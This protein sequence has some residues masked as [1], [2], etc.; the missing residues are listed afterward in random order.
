MPVRE[1]LRQGGTALLIC[2]SVACAS[3]E[4]DRS[5]GARADSSRETSRPVASTA[6]TPR[7]LRIPADSEVAD[8]N[9]RRSIARGRAIM[10]A[11]ADSLPGHVRAR[12]RCMS[13]HLD[14]GARVNGLPLIG[15]YVRYPQYRA[16]AGRV[17][18]IEDRVNECLER[19]LNG[20]AIAYDSQEM[21]DLVAYFAFMSRGTAVGDVVDGVGLTRLTPMEPD[22]VRGRALFD[23]RCASC[24]GAD[25]A[26]RAAVPPLW[27]PHAYNI[28]AGMARVRTAAA[29]IR[30]NMP[31][32]RPGSLTDQEAWDIAGYVNTRPRPD[33]APKIND[34]PL[35]DPPP[36]L[37]YRTRAGRRT[38]R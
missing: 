15:V 28:G 18:V 23:A 14:R 24:H 22:T 34:W 35:G 17:T 32:D 26:G 6:A 11:T 1:R 27:G 30:H 2:A 13:C 9:L 21:R 3:G 36:G 29:F 38:E 12:M 20:R 7:L 37:E 4:E 19:S 10:D 8:S 16:R 25:G 31:F 33:Y 5:A